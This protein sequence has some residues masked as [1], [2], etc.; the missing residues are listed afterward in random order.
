MLTPIDQLLDKVVQFATLTPDPGV[1]G[2]TLRQATCYV[3]T[4]TLTLWL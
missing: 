3:R 2:H 4:K 1:Q